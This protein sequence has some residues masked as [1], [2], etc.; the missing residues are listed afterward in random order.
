MY[1]WKYS[2]ESANSVVTFY[3]KDTM[4]TTKLTVNSRK[5][6]LM[7]SLLQYIL[8]LRGYAEWGHLEGASLEGIF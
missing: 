8:I 2:L 7:R 3:K 4:A 1:Q 6:Q 5:R